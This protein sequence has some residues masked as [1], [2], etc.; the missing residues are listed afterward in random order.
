MMQSPRP[1][2]KVQ[3]RAESAT[4]NEPRRVDSTSPSAYPSRRSVPGE[5]RSF[6]M[7]VQFASS[8]PAAD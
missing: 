3:I 1:G 2:G 7:T 5:R 6:Q 4:R 8:A